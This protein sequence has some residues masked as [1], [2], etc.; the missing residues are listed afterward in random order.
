MSLSVSFQPLPTLHACYSVPIEWSYVGNASVQGDPSLKLVFVSSVSCMVSGSHVVLIL[1][2]GAFISGEQ[3]HCSILVTRCIPYLDA[4]RDL[5]DVHSSLINSCRG[6]PFNPRRRSN[7]PIPRSPRTNH[8]AIHQNRHHA[9]PELH[10]L[11]M[12]ANRASFGHI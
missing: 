1:S 8:H 4:V 10:V 2:S 12:G 9:S 11:W 6:F 7:D 5:D 3:G